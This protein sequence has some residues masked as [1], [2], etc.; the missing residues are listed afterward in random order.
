VPDDLP[1]AALPQEGG[2]GHDVVNVANVGLML[3]ACDVSEVYR[4]ALRSTLNDG[5]SVVN[6][7]HIKVENINAGVNDPSPATVGDDLWGKIGTKY[8]AMFTTQATVHDLHLLEEL[9]PDD[10]SIPRFYIKSLEVAGTR[11]PPTAVLQASLTAMIRLNTNAPVRGAKGRMWAPPP[12]GSGDVI[13]GG[14]WDLTGVWGA[15]VTAFGTEWAV[16]SPH[17]TGL[18][19]YHT[20]PVVYSRTRR[21]RGEP[22][23]YFGITSAAV[24]PLQRWLDS[25]ASFS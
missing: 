3:Y 10:H 8:R 22:F 5:T 4:V 25:R 1:G 9:A 24:D 17:G 14:K 18:D 20:V 2:L 6:T 13:S 11:S 12:L 15:A 16:T 23:Y 21:R 19:E 7:G